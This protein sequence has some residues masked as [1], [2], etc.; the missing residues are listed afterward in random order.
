MGTRMRRTR[1]QR[2]RLRCSGAGG[3]RVCAH[4]SMHAC[5]QRAGP[6]SLALESHA[7]AHRD[8][9]AGMDRAEKD[10]ACADR[11]P[12]DLPR[13]RSARSSRPSASAATPP[14]ARA[15]S[16]GPHWPSLRLP[17]SSWRVPEPPAPGSCAPRWRR[18]GEWQ[19]EACVWAGK[20]RGRWGGGGGLRRGVEDRT[21]KDC[22]MASA[23]SACTASRSPSACIASV[24]AV[25][26]AFVP[27]NQC[28]W[29]PAGLPLGHPMYR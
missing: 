17:R 19:H 21:F 18:R 26:D 14:R 15:R 11:S 10:G 16:S 9:A 7:R 4:A 24:T 6:A 20:G 12:T 27:H 8:E 23:C 25:P 1:G 13:S 2:G 22:C 28:Q 3:G 29:A 5:M